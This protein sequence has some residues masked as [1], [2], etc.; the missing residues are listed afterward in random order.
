MQGWVST[1]ACAWERV[2]PGAA[3]VGEGG[4]GAPSSSG[5]SI[6]GKWLSAQLSG[7]MLGWLGGVEAGV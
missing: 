3:G 4:T 6:A 2:R 5:V 1:G 7:E